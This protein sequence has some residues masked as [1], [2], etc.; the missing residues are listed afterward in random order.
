[1]TS[2]AVGTAARQKEALRRVVAATVERPWVDAV[3]LVG[4]LAANAADALSDD[5]TTVNALAR[6]LGVDWHTLWDALKVEAHRRAD[7]PE[8]LSGVESLGVDEHIWRPGKFGAGR[9]WFS[10]IEIRPT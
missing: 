10:E 4:S 7:D 3:V 8:R 2:V 9:R 1:M 6:R 5:D